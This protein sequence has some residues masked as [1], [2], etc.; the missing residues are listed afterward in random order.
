MSLIGTLGMGSVSLCCKGFLPPSIGTLDNL[1]FIE[2]SLSEM[3]NLFNEGIFNFWHNN[4]FYSVIIRV[5]LE[6][7]SLSLIHTS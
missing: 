4:Y 5:G 6:N 3:F 7:W 2:S 1:I